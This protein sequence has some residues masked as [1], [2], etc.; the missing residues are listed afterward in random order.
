MHVPA[1]QCSNLR[2]IEWK[3]FYSLE[4]KIQSLI[5][6]LLEK[7]TVFK[8]SHCIDLPNVLQRK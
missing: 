4:H 2:I 5:S 1:Y 3:E 8:I 6:L 7:I